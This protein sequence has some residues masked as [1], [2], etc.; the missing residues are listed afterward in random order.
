MAAAVRGGMVQLPLDRVRLDFFGGQTT[1]GVTVI[2]PPEP[3]CLNPQSISASSP[4]R[5]EDIR[6]NRNH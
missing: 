6:S 5:H 4:I 3:D 1:S 2:L